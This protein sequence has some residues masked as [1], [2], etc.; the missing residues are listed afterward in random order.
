MSFVGHLPLG[1]VLI[2]ELSANGA[3]SMLLFE[4]VT[5]TNWIISFAQDPLV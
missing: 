2:L 3:I 5:L 4:P 1:Q